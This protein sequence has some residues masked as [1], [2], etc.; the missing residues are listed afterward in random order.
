LSKEKKNMSCVLTVERQ[1]VPKH[2]LLDEPQAAAGRR[3]V[4]VRD[5]SG[6]ER[7]RELCFRADDLR[8]QPLQL[9]GRCV[10]AVRLGLIVDVVAVAQSKAVEQ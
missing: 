1:D 3:V 8:P 5:A 4:R 10:V 9:H 7:R 2:E 6:P